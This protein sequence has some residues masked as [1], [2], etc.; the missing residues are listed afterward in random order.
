MSTVTQLLADIIYI[1]HDFLI[2]ALK[3]S[4]QKKEHK[5]P[6]PV[7]KVDGMLA[8]F[9]FITSPSKGL[10]GYSLRYS[11][12]KRIRIANE[13]ISEAGWREGR[14]QGKCRL[15]LRGRQVGKKREEEETFLRTPTIQPVIRC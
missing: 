4:T 11:G 6:G 7:G 9:S 14:M 2:T 5:S 3:Y 1:Y 12:G 13:S 15:H 10:I 8:K